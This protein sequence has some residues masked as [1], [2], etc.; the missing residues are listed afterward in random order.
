MKIEELIDILNK[1]K[2]KV[3]NLIKILRKKRDFIEKKDT[4]GVKEILTVEK[5]AV[6]ELTF[7][8][9]NRAELT[10]N[11]AEELGTAPTVSGILEKTE[12][13]YRHDLT[14]I[15]A[16]LTELLNEVSLLNIGIQ[17]MIAY[18]MEEFD[19]VIDLLRGKRA[20]Y[21]DSKNR[22]AGTIFNGRA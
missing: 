14:L 16:R 11:F 5:Q 1:E 20:T 17:Q 7:L 12:D 4:D 8:E 21:D 19:M 15:A 13:P 22:V 3:A 2:E 6:D 10:K 18:R 9:K